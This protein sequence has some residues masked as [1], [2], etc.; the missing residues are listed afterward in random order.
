MFPGTVR[1]LPLF[2]FEKRR[3]QGHVTP[4]IHLADMCCLGAPSSFNNRLVIALKQ[5][6]EQSKQS[7]TSIVKINVLQGE[8]YVIYIFFVFY[9]F[10]CIIIFFL[11]SM[12]NRVS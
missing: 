6:D 8:H 12:V 10:H 2:L 7:N 5:S 3:G 4:K 9:L 1:S 11:P